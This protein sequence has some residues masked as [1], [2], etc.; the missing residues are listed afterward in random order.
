MVLESQP[1]VGKP[2]GSKE[3]L[4]L[5]KVALTILVVY[6][7]R[8]AIAQLAAVI[9]LLLPFLFSSFIWFKSIQTGE[10]I[11]DILREYVTL[12]PIAYAER[13]KKAFV[14]WATLS[15]VLANAAVFYAMSLLGPKGAETVIDR[16]SFLPVPGGTLNTLLSP[17]AHMFLHGNAGHLW[18]N[19]AFLWAFA[20]SLEERLGR[21]KLLAWFLLTGV[22]GGMASIVVFRLFFHRVIHGI[23]AS[24]AVAGIMGIF[25]VRCYFKKLVIPVPI[26][27]L[28]SVKLKVNSLLV[29]GLFFLSDLHNGFR[30]LG[31]SGLAIGFWAH[32]GGML[33]GSG[34]ALAFRLHAK[35]A[36]E[37]YTEAGL[38]ASDRQFSRR[39]SMESL[40]A[41]L[42]L[43]PENEEA[44]LGL[45][46]ECAVT[47]RP[48]G[49]ELFQRAIQLKLRSQPAQ[50]LEVFREYRSTYPQMLDPELQYRLAGAFYKEN[51][52]EPAARLLEAI[53]LEPSAPDGTR[54]RAFYQLV[55][56]LAENNMLEAA[57]FRLGQFKEQFPAAEL[58]KAAED[59]FVEMLKS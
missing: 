21:K 51:D 41:A 6:W 30:Q 27:G 52:H 33:T 23:G 59:K 45:A 31:G 13:G 5:L 10:R 29:I 44:L 36:E 39:E 24:G 17:L 19:M 53:I 40:Q 12:V 58:A 8:E 26:L 25:M 15:L 38:A 34:L 54:Q 9:W 22:A 4:Y 56:L 49:R 20:P 28:L 35:A 11:V 47:R 18:G 42:R 14:P 57:H 43:N 2:F 46:R 3:K 55:V 37:K 16:F 1:Y 48:E 7:L 32:V 50:A